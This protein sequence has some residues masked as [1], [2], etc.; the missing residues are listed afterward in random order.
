[1][2]NQVKI[3]NLLPEISSRHTSN[4]YWCLQPVSFQLIEMTVLP[5]PRNLISY[6]QGQN[7]YL[8]D[9]RL[10]FYQPSE[11]RYYEARLNLN[12]SLDI[13]NLLAC[14]RHFRPLCLDI[15]TPQSFVSHGYVC[16]R[17]GPDTNDTR[18][19]DR[20]FIMVS[21]IYRCSKA[22]SPCL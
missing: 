7:P 14:R 8:R 10:L 21:R 9:F 6:M 2:L 19:N 16:I 20:T 5:K 18:P 15:S 11:V 1:M 22:G 12:G 3:R 13:W 4:L 17:A